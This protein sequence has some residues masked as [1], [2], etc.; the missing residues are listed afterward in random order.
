VSI[1][2]LCARAEARGRE[3]LKYGGAARVRLESDQGQ[4]V[5]PRGYPPIRLRAFM[6]P[7][8]WSMAARRRDKTPP[9]PFPKSLQSH[10]FAMP[11]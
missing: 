3:I 11:H 4:R 1:S 6:R 8:A 2:I 9:P 5:D 7:L 10:L